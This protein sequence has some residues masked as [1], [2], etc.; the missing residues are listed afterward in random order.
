MKSEFTTTVIFCILNLNLI[1]AY[2]SLVTRNFNS[3]V[4]SRS[5]RANMCLYEMMY[6]E[7][8]CKGSRTQCI[9]FKKRCS[10][11]ASLLLI[12]PVNII[13]WRSSGQ[14]SSSSRTSDDIPPNEKHQLHWKGFI[15][16]SWS[17][18]SLKTFLR[19]SLS[20]CDT[21]Q[22]ERRETYPIL[23]RGVYRTHRRW[24]GLLVWNCVNI[25]KDK[26]V[27]R[28]LIEIG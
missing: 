20:Q 21:G 16:C 26:K 6:N 19:T 9:S 1:S 13:T 27:L 5:R 25:W 4:N 17:Q 24:N 15:D 10:R 3:L 28:Y 14:A 8:T 2:F 22:T 23:D 18:Y 12:V 11:S 7:C